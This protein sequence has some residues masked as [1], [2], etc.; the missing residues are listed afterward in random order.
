MDPLSAIGLASNIIQFVDFGC[1]LISGAQEVCKLAASAKVIA[2]E[3]QETIARLQ[4]VPGPR[5]RWRSFRQALTTIWQRDRIE[6]LS[7]RL[8]KL[9]RSLSLL[10]HV[11]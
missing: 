5:R 9:Q 4:L 11:R 3:L 6:S 7:G 2:D 1:E 10:I 8:E